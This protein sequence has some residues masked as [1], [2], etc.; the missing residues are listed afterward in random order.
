MTQHSHKHSDSHRH[1]R[2]AEAESSTM[3]F[4]KDWRVWLAVVIMLA[5][6]IIYV[7]TLDDSI[8]PVIIR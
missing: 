7:L 8:I 3:K 4:H 2:A 1:A 5:A 6:A